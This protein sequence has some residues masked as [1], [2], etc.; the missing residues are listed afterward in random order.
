MQL[1]FLTACLPQVPFEDV[2]RWAAAE[3][4]DAI[5]LAAWPRKMRRKHVAGQLDVANLTADDAARARAALA[6]NGIRISAMA[7]YENN[8]HPAA[9]RRGGDP[10]PLRNG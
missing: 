7:Y 9:T 5:E 3:G 2:V 6:E 8:L 1:G 10:R 4:F